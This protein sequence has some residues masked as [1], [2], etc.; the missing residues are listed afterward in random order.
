M[1]M[2]LRRVF[3]AVLLATCTPVA[4]AGTPDCDGPD[5]WAAGSAYAQLKNAALTAPTHVDWDRVTVTLLAS[6]Q[7]G[8]D[9]HRQVHLIVF[10]HKDGRRIEVITRN[11][12]SSEE[13]SM[14]PVEVY[15]VST[16][17]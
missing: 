11:D 2:Q 16:K 13:C 5:N 8:P 14:G 9:L 6:E 12:A 1:P 4:E 7:V 3:L 10:P 17:L 15:V